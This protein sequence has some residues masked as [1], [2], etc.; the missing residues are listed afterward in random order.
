MVV[1]TISIVGLLADRQD[2]L[3]FASE[4]LS[5]GWVWVQIRKLISILFAGFIALTAALA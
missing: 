3:E 2:T 1:G 4:Q 5:R